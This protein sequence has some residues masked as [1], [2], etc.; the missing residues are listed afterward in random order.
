LICIEQLKL[1]SEFREFKNFDF[2]L[3]WKAMAAITNEAFTLLP[4]HIWSTEF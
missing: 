3:S 1:D 2:W 4:I